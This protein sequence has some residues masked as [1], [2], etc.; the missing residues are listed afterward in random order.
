LTEFDSTSAIAASVIL[1]VIGVAVF[2][3]MPILLGS[4]A[5]TLAISDQQ[6]GW[7]AS[8]DLGGMSVASIATY[9]LVTR[10]NRRHIALSGIVIAVAANL[11]STQLAVFDLLFP[12]RI[13]SGVG[14]GLCYATGIAC[15]AGSH[16]TA[17]NFSILLFA[18]IAVNALQL[19]TFPTLSALWGVNAI[20]I[21]FCGLF[22]L[23]IPFLKWIPRLAEEVALDA[24]AEDH[25]ADHNRH[26][27]RYLPRL[28]LAAICIVYIAIGSFWAYVERMGV[29]AGLT[30]DFIRYA[31]TVG[32]AFSLVGC[33]LATWL[34]NRSGQSRPLMVA[35]VCL[36]AVMAMLMLGITPALFAVGLF[37]FNF[38][39]I[40]VDIYQLG[41]IA[42]IDHSG[43]YAA[44]VPAAQ[45]ISITLGPSI[46]ALILDQ[47]LGYRGVL[48]LGVIGPMA[49]FILYSVVYAHLKQIVPD[50]ADAS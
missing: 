13:L 16:H 11:L 47:G 49:G 34:S 32:T 17:R 48:I 24:V 7:L 8:A 28:C 31:L 9:Y 15:L 45:G 37:S 40:F 30:D 23:C 38:F 35:L 4:M 1:A 12:A 29:D 46:A 21:A 10:V 36:S 44:L 18:Q 3:G 27:P 5:D 41:T 25:P 20:Y 22:V 26:I 50:V 39:W 43:R 6:A 2:Q 14:S 19:F 33:G 42:N